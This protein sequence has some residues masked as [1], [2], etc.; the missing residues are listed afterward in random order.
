VNDIRPFSTF[1]ESGAFFGVTIGS[2]LQDLEARIPLEFAEN[3]VGGRTKLLYRDYGLIE[4]TFTRRDAW[5]CTNAI[6]QL[7]RLA[8]ADEV[9]QEWSE[10]MDT[11]LPDRVRWDELLAD[12]ERAG[13]ARVQSTQDHVGTV[14]YRFDTDVSANV[15]T[16]KKLVAGSLEVGDVWSLSLYRVRT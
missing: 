13:T 2:S 9:R 16:E 12:V 7:H 14:E 5:E 3:L 6:A 8:K 4:F 10:F 11:E 1:I 15:V